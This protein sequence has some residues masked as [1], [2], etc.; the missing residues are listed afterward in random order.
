MRAVEGDHHKLLRL[1]I[2][3]C[4]NRE[5]QGK[6]ERG[7]RDKAKHGHRDYLIGHVLIRKPLAL[8]ASRV[9]GSGSCKRFGFSLLLKCGKAAV[10]LAIFRHSRY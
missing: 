8:F 4:R 3:L 1:F 7:K 6:G 9:F 10:P 2:G 5:S